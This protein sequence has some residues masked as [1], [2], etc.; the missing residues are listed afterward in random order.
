MK[1]ALTTNN[2]LNARFHPA[3]FVGGW[4]DAFGK[5]ELHG[6]WVVYGKSFQGKTTFCLQLAKYLTRFCNRV[7]YDSLEQGLSYSMQQ[8]WVN[9]NIIDVGRKI[10]LLDKETPTELME[11][12]RKKQSADVIIIDSYRYFEERNFKV[13][14]NLK[15]MFLSKLFIVIA[16]EDTKG[17]PDGALGKRLYRDA[18]VKIRVSGR[19]AFVNSRFGGNNVPMV[20]DN[21]FVKQLK[22][23]F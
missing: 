12:L 17:L 5:P 4:L 7:A 6:L 9:N 19:E 20:I 10:V 14:T 16:H 3:E 1:R 23:E 8:A 11:R 22:A 13:Y 2:I 21:E 18:D 15:Y